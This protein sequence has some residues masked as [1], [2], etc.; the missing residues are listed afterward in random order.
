MASRRGHRAEPG[1][2]PAALQGDYGPPARWRRF[3]QGII[4]PVSPTA[5]DP[6]SCLSRLLRE[7]APVRIAVSGGVDSLT[8]AILAGRSLGHRAAMLHAVS[9]AVPAEA[10]QRVSDLGAREGWALRLI[11]AGEFADEAYLANPYDR[12]FHCKTHLYAAMARVGVGTL[13]SGTN[14]DDL[15]DYRPGLRAAQDH[16]VRH[17]FVEAGVDKQGVRAL[18]RRLGHPAIADLPAAPCLS[19]RVE[20]GLRIEPGAL[21]FVH[22]VER[23]VAEALWPRVV[24]C[25][26]RRDAVV[27]ELDEEA[28][29]HLDGAAQAW[30]DRV[31]ALA[32]LH[33]LPDEIRFEPYR[34]GSAFV[35]HR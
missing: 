27:V 25:R 19:S 18:C 10:T 8:L 26:V 5:E 32:R 6:L 13:L 4:R 21:T 29:G 11:D 22:R 30:R 9:P 34:R 1:A 15:D 12:C 23:E 7:L 24:R 31:A 28:L 16:G 33:G 3:R 20:T 2:W 35:A 17:P 14:T